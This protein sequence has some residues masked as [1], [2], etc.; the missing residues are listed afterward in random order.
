MI[1]H[2][3]LLDTDKGTN[4]LVIVRQEMEPMIMELT[5]FSGEYREKYGVEKD[6]QQLITMM[7]KLIGEGF[8]LE[9]SNTTLI[10][11]K[12]RLFQREVVYIFAKEEEKK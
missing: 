3:T 9:T 7:A 12:D 6:D 8:E 4:M 1:K 11:V 10:P 5:P 2:I